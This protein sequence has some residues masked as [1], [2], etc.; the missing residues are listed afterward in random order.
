MKKR[1]NSMKQ[2]ILFP[3]FHAVC[4]Q[5]PGGYFFY[6]WGQKYLNKTYAQPPWC[7]RDLP[8]IYHSCVWL[9]HWGRSQLRAFYQVGRE[10]E[11]SQEQS[12]VLIMHCLN[13]TTQHVILQISVPD[14]ADFPKVSKVCGH[15]YTKLHEMG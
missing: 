3:T 6:C 10:G 5:S 13:D 14:N 2:S 1:A 11:P 9:L 15:Q 8:W 12:N 7:F 4:P